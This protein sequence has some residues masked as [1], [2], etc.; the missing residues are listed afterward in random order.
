M[1]ESSI[2][3]QLS[4]VIESRKSG[5][6]ETSYVTSLLRG[7]ESRVL[8]KIGE[9]AVELVVAVKDVDVAAMTHE[10]ADLWFHVMVVLSRHGIRSEQVL[11][12]LER[13]F[14]ISG[15]E[16]KSSRKK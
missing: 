2:L 10:A 16:E 12:E 4:D 13:R 7:D 8:K 6:P 1:G 15:L 11:S 5:D 3:E 9:E 14:G